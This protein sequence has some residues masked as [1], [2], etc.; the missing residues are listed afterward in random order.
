[1]LSIYSHTYTLYLIVTGWVQTDMGNSAGP[2]PVTV[3][4]SVR[5]ITQLLVTAANV[6]TKVGCGGVMLCVV[7]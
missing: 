6:Q 5:G 7:L 3:P 4:D 1:L 2:A